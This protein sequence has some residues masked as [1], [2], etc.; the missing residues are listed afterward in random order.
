MAEV[1]LLGAEVIDLKGTRRL[2]DAG[3]Q[4]AL[5]SYL[6]L[7]ADALTLRNASFFKRGVE[8]C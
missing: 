4:D 3:V 7:G 5:Q 8:G 1:Y 6:Y 2:H